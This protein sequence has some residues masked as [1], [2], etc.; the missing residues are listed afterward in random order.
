MR[1]DVPED[2]RGTL[3]RRPGE[4]R[5]DVAE[6]QY[7]GGDDGDAVCAAPLLDTAAPHT[8]TDT[9]RQARHR[10]YLFCCAALPELQRR[11]VGW[12]NAA[13]SPRGTRAGAVWRQWLSPWTVLSPD[14]GDLAHTTD[15]AAAAADDDDLRRRPHRRH[16]AA[17]TVS[18]AR[19]MRRVVCIGVLSVVALV[20]LMMLL[21]VVLGLLLSS[22][23]VGG[24]PQDF[25]VAWLECDCIA[26]D[27]LKDTAAAADTAVQHLR[28]VVAAATDATCSLCVRDG[29]AVTA[30]VER[31]SGGAALRLAVGRVRAAVAA[32][33]A[34]L[35]PHTATLMQWARFEEDLRQERVEVARRREQ[36]NRGVTGGAVRVASPMAPALPSPSQIGVVDGPW[37]R[38]VA[39]PA[40]VAAPYMPYYYVS[41]GSGDARA[42][43]AE[44]AP[45]EMT[46]L[47]RRALPWR[48]IVAAAPRT[49]AEE[50]EA[51]A[52]TRRPPVITIAG[53]DRI[54]RYNS[55]LCADL[56]NASYLGAGAYRLDPL[57][58]ALARWTDPSPA[59]AAS[60]PVSRCTGCD[61]H[62]VHPRLVERHRRRHG[63]DTRSA[64]G[65]AAAA[66]L[67]WE[68]A[69]EDVD[70]G[71][72]RLDGDATAPVVTRADLFTCRLLSPARGEASDLENR[73]LLLSADAW[74]A[75]F[76]GGLPMLFTAG[77]N[78]T[79]VERLLPLHTA[80]IFGESLQS[81]AKYATHASFWLQFDAVYLQ[82]HV[83]RPE[84]LAKHLAAGDRQDVGGGGPRSRAAPPTRFSTWT[85]THYYRRDFHI[86]VYLNQMRRRLLQRARQNGDDGGAAAAATS[87]T[88]LELT[89]ADVPVALP[90]LPRSPRVQ[91][92]DAPAARAAGTV[93]RLAFEVLHGADPLLLP[94]RGESLLAPGPPPVAWRPPTAADWHSGPPQTTAAR[95][96]PL[97]P[98]SGNTGRL[99]AIVAVISHCWH[100]RMWWLSELSRYYPVHNYGRCVIPPPTPLPG[101]VAPS[102]AIPQRAR[103][104]FPAECAV[105][106]IRQHH[107]SAL[108]A[109]RVQYGDAAAEGR[110]GAAAAAAAARGLTHVA[111]DHEL[112]CIFR[113]YRYVIA[114]ENTVEDDY[115]TEKVYNALLSGALPLYIGAQNI[116]DYVPRSSSRS[117]GGAGTRASA[118]AAAA[119][120]AGVNSSASVRG[121]S[122]MPVLQLFPMLNETAWRAE[123]RRRHALREAEDAVTR[124]VL[125]THAAVLRERASAAATTAAAAA[126]M[127]RTVAL[128]LEEVAAQTPR[129]VAA[130]HYLF[131]GNASESATGGNRD[132]APPTRPRRTDGD[133]VREYSEASGAWP[134][135]SPTAGPTA[136]AAPSPPPPL[137]HQG[138]SELL[139]HVHA[140]MS[141][142]RHG[143][144]ARPSAVGTDAHG[145]RKVRWR[146]DEDWVLTPNTAWGL[147]ADVNAS[148]HHHHH[149]HRGNSPGAAPA[150]SVVQKFERGEGAAA[151]PATEGNCS[152]VAGDAYSRYFHRLCLPPTP[153]YERVLKARTDAAAAAA[154]V[155][156]MNGFAQLAAYLRA[157]D[158]DPALVE[159]AGYLD[160]WRA[161]RVEDLGDAFVSNLDAPHPVCAI[162]ADALLKKE[163]LP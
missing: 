56:P 90:W 69:L 72:V 108:A 28:A 80:A 49:D 1:S 48:S 92:A 71:H 110:G 121:L 152:A 57:R 147:S 14:D 141:A 95:A 10:V 96:A 30:A 124:R 34:A 55:Y 161:E 130:E 75:H 3:K 47:H 97:L 103:L 112:R 120:G 63:A 83:R 149:H 157:L 127:A 54:L 62:C 86:I 12:L 78:A 45:L 107:R 118:T 27:V 119:A 6:P 85:V 74:L 84:R 23:G 145:L 116:A 13:L 31:H 134:P 46:F 68:V 20:L 128:A 115:V 139:R 122:V 154:A 40:V 32:V 65:G 29:D 104:P 113:K 100:N 67:S 26:A 51:P 138:N 143:T 93:A 105:D 137:V 61:F 153:A 5:A 132:D 15:G 135:P 22:A 144:T 82:N 159:E 58:A 126:R 77:D 109:M 79:T 25:A 81:F 129:D 98:F 60:R 94:M 73:A 41:S 76:G 156:P 37:A 87:N 146:A 2:R 102:R 8:A 131:Y 158:D 7:G 162:C 148:A 33:G 50:R 59:R 101:D 150:A 53:A 19:L 52:Q 88:T 42:A 18:A 35:L 11:V 142:P 99:P 133:A 66:P 9:M 44:R 38:G 91:D 106:K 111:R 43:C 21:D 151:A 17:P 155:P 125:Q 39:E 16:A 70:A 114:F 24:E 89:S 64:G 36:Q 136:R 4:R 160:W 140:A 117:S 163:A 123:V